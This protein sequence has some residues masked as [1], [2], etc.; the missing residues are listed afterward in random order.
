MLEKTKINFNFKEF[1]KKLFK[2]MTLFSSFILNMVIGEINWNVDK[3]IIEDFTDIPVAIYSLGAMFNTYFI[4][5]TAVQ[6]FCSRVHK[7]VQSTD[8]K[9]NN[10]LFTK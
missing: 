10:N 1:D 7:L 8:D 9:R 3:F 5:P 2:E 4:Q 6:V